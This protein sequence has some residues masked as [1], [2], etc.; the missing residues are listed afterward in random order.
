[1][2]NYKD[3]YKNGRYQRK[4]HTITPMEYHNLYYEAA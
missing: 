2:E 4:L 1:M 3:Y